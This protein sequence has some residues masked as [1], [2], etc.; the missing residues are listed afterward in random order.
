MWYYIEGCD[1]IKQSTVV[2]RIILG[3]ELPLD[4]N[5]SQ[6]SQDVFKDDEPS[7]GQGF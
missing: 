1:T 2:G 4:V 3:E 5:F 7:S 6:L